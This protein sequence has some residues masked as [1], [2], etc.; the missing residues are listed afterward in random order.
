MVSTT[1]LRLRIG[2]VELLVETLDTPT[3]RAIL[4][5]VPFDSR[6]QRWGE[7]VYFTTPV[8]VEREPDAREVVEPGEIAFW[9]EGRAIAIAFGPTPVSRAGEPRLVSPCNVWARACDDVRRL[10]AVAEGAPVRV[11]RADP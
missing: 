2:P 4:A 6:A 3:A 10:A 11:E 1:R 7:E 8:E 9:P 5:A